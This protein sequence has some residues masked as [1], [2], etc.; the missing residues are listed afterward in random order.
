MKYILRYSYFMIDECICVSRTVPFSLFPTDLFNTI[1][2]WFHACRVVLARNCY[3]ICFGILLIAHE[4]E[5]F[6]V[7]ILPPYMPM[8][9]CRTGDV[10]KPAYKNQAYNDIWEVGFTAEYKCIAWN[11]HFRSN[12]SRRIKIW[13]PQDLFVYFLWE[14]FGQTISLLQGNALVFWRDSIGPTKKVPVSFVPAKKNGLRSCDAET[15]RKRQCALT[16]AQSKECTKKKSMLLAVCD[17]AYL[18]VD[19]PN[20]TWTDKHGAV[21]LILQYSQLHREV[22]NLET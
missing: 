2:A 15:H 16:G 13:R 17:W 1:E 18:L 20:E 11:T 10:G 4:L 14:L 3:V 6:C 19:Y 7:K 21:G 5:P 9:H 8:L 12:F 22:C